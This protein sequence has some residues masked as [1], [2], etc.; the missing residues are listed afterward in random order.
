AASP[1]QREAGR[2]YLEGLLDVL[3]KACGNEDLF[4]DDSKSRIEDFVSK[5]IFEPDENNMYV[6]PLVEVYWSAH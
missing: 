1:Q 2:I 5:T 3:E 6:E 4:Q